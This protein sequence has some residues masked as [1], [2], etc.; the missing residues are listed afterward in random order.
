M[1][2]LED[3]DSSFTLRRENTCLCT[4]KSV[5]CIFIFKKFLMCE[6]TQSLQ[7]FLHRLVILTLFSLGLVL[8]IVL[9]CS[10]LEFKQ[11]PDT[12]S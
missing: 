3:C 12:T 8:F 5:V 9:E 2:H 4:F 1:Q 10:I 7:R 6:V 11:T